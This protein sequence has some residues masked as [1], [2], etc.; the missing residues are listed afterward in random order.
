M[1]SVMGRKIH[2][3]STH[4]ICRAATM[5]LT[6]VPKYN[7]IVCVCSSHKLCASKFGT[8]SVVPSPL[9]LPCIIITL[10]T[11]WSTMDA[12]NDSDSVADV[13]LVEEKDN[14]GCKSYDEFLSGMYSY[15]MMLAYD[16]ATLTPDSDWRNAAV[17]LHRWHIYPRG[18]FCAVHTY[19]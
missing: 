6:A 16:R 2:W 7:E 9:A 18:P 8:A 11:P 15:S 3:P 4:H 5:H 14:T 17:Y 19:R 10:A 12:S 13:T 1:I